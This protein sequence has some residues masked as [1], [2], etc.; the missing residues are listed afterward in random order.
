MDIFNAESMVE[1]MTGCDA[2]LSCLG[3]HGIAFRSVPSPTWAPA[4][5]EEQV[6]LR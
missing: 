4:S 1:G 3:L 5:G 2:V 6:A